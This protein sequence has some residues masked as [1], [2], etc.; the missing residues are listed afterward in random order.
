MKIL[1]V[2][3]V[4]LSV[5]RCSYISVLGVT[6]SR[7]VFAT[8]MQPC[9]LTVGANLVYYRGGGRTKLR[10]RLICLHAV[11]KS[12]RRHANVSRFVEVLTAKV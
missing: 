4:V 2:N 1:A 3:D 7:R 9:S 5:G 12:T 11:K 6:L 10:L 8:T